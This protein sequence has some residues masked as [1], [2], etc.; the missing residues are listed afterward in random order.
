M[1]FALVNGPLFSLDAAGQIGKALVY[2]KWKGRAY[3]REYVTPANPRSLAQQFQRGMLTAL[4]AWWQYIKGQ[5]TLLDSWLALAAASNFSTFN[6]YTKTNLDRETIGSNPITNTESGGATVNGETDTVTATGGINTISLS[7]AIAT[8]PIVSDILML[9]LGTDGG[10]N[11]TAQT[12]Q[13]TVAARANTTNDATWIVD[14]TDIPAG[15]YHAAARFIG[16]DGVGS[17]WASTVTAA[18]VTGTA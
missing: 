17:A 8:A 6:A 3:V 5:S 10:A 14:L 16:S 15:V 18:T 2:A 13:R 12:I 11:T 4:V 9:S 7:I 1:L